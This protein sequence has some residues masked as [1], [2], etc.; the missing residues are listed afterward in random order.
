MQVEVSKFVGAAIQTTSGIRGTVKKS[1]QPTAQNATPG[2]FRATFEDKLVQSD[3]VMLKAWV[4]V[5]V[6][7]FWNPVTN[8]LAQGSEITRGQKHRASRKNCEYADPGTGKE[9]AGVDNAADAENSTE[10]ANA[11]VHEQPDQPGGSTGWVGART[12]A[13][14]RRGMGVGA[15]R[16]VDSLYKQISRVERVFPAL[17]VPKNLQKALPFATKPKV[18]APRKRQTLEQRRAVPMEKDEKKVHSSIHPPY[19]LSVDRIPAYHYI[20][21][22][23][24][25]VM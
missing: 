25:F 9:G 5:R 12:V 11:V 13:Q 24:V 20:S 21:I 17:K 7:Q 19:Y 4:A 1:V 18:E 23:H 14:M 2:S 15:R 6:P 10:A 22:R 3:L 8:H 16:E